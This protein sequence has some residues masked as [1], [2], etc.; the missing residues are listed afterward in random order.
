MIRI[1]RFRNICYK[2]TNK[3]WFILQTNRTVQQNVPVQRY[4]DSLLELTTIENHSTFYWNFDEVSPF[5]PEFRNV[6][7]RYEEDLHFIFA[8]LHPD[9]IMHNM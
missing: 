1:C 7:V 2:P 8:R 6:E 4:A 3:K 9:N 5:D